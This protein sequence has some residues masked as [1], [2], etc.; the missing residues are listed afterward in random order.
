MKKQAIAILILITFTLG[1]V[2][3]D[4][5]VVNEFVNEIEQQTSEESHIFE[6][7]T[8]EETTDTEESI[9]DNTLRVGAFNIQVFGVTKADKPE[10]M[11]VIADIVRTYDI[12]AIQEIRD[13]SQ[14]ALP[15]L[16]DLVNSDGPNYQYVVSERL[17]RTTSKEQYAYIYNSNTVEVIGD[18]QTYPEPENT[19]PFHRQPYI[20]SFKSISGNYDAVLMVIHTDP[21]EATEEINAL[22][23]VLAYSQSIYPDEQDF[24]IMGDINADGSYFDEDSTSD[25][26]EYYW[27]IDD[28]Q[29]TTVASSDNTYDRII[30]TDS[31]DLSGQSGVFRY[32]LEYNLTEDLTSDVSDHYP[33]YAEFSINSDN[34]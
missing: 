34:D 16:V 6:P 24:I 10:V 11:D 14:T 13:S 12:V 21:D 3:E 7:T 1:C 8:I 22:D 29:D 31:S 32:D 4:I 28:S 20:A 2:S 33:V 18:P 25:I 23:D 26:D 5:E 27:V 30:L 19:D 15:E 9:S 17:G